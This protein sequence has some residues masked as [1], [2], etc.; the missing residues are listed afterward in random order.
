VVIV[1]HDPGIAAN[2]RRQVRLHDGRV[3][4]DVSR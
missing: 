2:C 3:A 4:E 1:T